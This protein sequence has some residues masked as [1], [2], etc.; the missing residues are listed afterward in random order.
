MT[1]DPLLA[2]LDDQ[3]IVAR[4]VYGEARGE[5]AIGQ[6]AVLNVIFNRASSK[7]T[8]WGT[9]PRLVCLKPYQFSCWNKDDP[10]YG[11][12]TSALYGSIFEQVLDLTKQAFAGDLPDLT[13]G[14]DSYKVIGTSARWAENLKPVKLIGHHEFYRTV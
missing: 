6:Q 9:T 12:L 1:N 11:I 8:W 5:G 14:A 4:T 10:N 3:Q 7:T 2:Q 13:G